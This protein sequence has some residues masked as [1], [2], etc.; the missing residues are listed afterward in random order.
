[1]RYLH[2][3]GCVICT[4]ELICICGILRGIFVASPHMAIT[5]KVDI[6]VGRVMALI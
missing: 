3:H 1:M 5:Y 6:T 4:H 2:L